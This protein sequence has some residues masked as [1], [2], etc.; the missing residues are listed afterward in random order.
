MLGQIVEHWYLWRAVSTSQ[1][2]W[3]KHKWDWRKLQLDPT[4]YFP[5]MDQLSLIYFKKANR[6]ALYI[7][8]VI[9]NKLLM[10]KGEPRQRWLDLLWN[11]LLRMLKMIITITTANWY[12]LHAS[13]V[14]GTA[15]KIVH[16]VSHVNLL[17][18]PCS[19]FADEW[20][21][22]QKGNWHVQRHTSSECYQVTNPREFPSWLSG[23]ESD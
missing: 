18:A 17:R 20:T 6:G 4:S 2:E 22:A 5:R 21:E 23:N 14:P 12:L 10:S 7:C 13:H 11:F 3:W 19:T 8:S 9:N 1:W 15:L 16:M